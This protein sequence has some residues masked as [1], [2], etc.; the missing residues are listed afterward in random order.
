M[1]FK[2]SKY[3]NT[4]IVVDDM[5]FDSKKEGNRYKL[6]KLLEKKGEI[7]ELKL[8]VPFVL[9]PAQYVINYINKKVCV[10]REMKYIADFTYYVDDILIVED[11]KGFKTTEYKHK[12]ILM[13]KL[14]DIDIK[15]S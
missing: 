7:R 11:A 12:K 13:K 9:A 10:R 6:L 14:F 3:S 5:K 15:E 8:Q 2:K 1:K 4:K